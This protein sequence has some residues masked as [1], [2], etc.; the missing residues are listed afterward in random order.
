[1]SESEPPNYNVSA[2]SRMAMQGSQNPFITPSGQ[3]RRDN[4]PHLVPRGQ[5]THRHVHTP[6]MTSSSDKDDWVSSPW[7]H[8]APPTRV[9]TKRNRLT[10][11]GHDDR[12]FIREKTMA[13]I[14]SWPPNLCLSLNTNNWLEW[15]QHLI[16][17]LEMGQL[18]KYPLGLLECPD[19][20]T[21]R[22]GYSNWRGN[23]RMILRYMRSHMYSSETQCIAKCLTSAGAY[24]TL[25]QRHK[26]QSGLTQ[27]Q[28]IQR[29][30]QIC[31]DNSPTNFDTTMSQL[32]DLIY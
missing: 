16:T 18:D 26:K 22:T 31:F 10:H 19:R 12:P 30:M 29:M 5:I 6:T 8:L 24:N 23:D 17:S 4:P 28:L 25:R 13:G 7:Y 2:F 11:S 27:T 20:Q 21:D 15:S 9:Y 14:P 1:M 3:P 32:C